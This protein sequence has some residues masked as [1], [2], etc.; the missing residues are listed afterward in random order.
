MVTMA[1]EQGGQSLRDGLPASHPE[2]HR[3]PSPPRSPQ[4][5][6]G[7]P[8]PHRNRLRDD[9]LFGDV[10]ALKRWLGQRHRH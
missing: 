5:G 6:E 9:R 3:Q 1:A 7:A 8:A 2:P 4:S 10:L